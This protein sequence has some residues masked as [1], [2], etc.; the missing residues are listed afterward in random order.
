MNNDYNPCK[1]VTKKSIP[2]LFT[3]RNFID[4]FY[5]CVRAARIV[6]PDEASASRK[7]CCCRPHGLSDETCFDIY[8]SSVKIRA[9]QDNSMENKGPFDVSANF[10]VSFYVRHLKRLK[11][12][13]FSGEF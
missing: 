2:S 1:T 11:G 6:K 4:R 10:Y 9:I 7:I 12:M 3:L 5:C 8:T 13:K